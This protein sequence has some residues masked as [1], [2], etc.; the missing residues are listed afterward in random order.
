VPARPVER[1]TEALA[2]PYPVSGALMQIE[3]SVGLAVAEPLDDAST[4]LRR[5]DQAMYKAK[6]RRREATDGE[7]P[8]VPAADQTW[9]DR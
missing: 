8:P 9:V 6:L 1:V 3:A 5:A 2:R 4:L 7:V